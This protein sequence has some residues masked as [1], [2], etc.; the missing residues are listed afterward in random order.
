MRRR[1]WE[2]ERGKE[3]QKSLAPVASKCFF[4][5]TLSLFFHAVPRRPLRG[6]LNIS[7]N[8]L[9]ESERRADRQEG[10]ATPGEAAASCWTGFLSGARRVTPPGLQGEHILDRREGGGGGSYCQ[11]DPERPAVLWRAGRCDDVFDV[12]GCRCREAGSRQGL[13]VLLNRMHPQ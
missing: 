1:R 12:I 5:S 3:G 7:G 10:R 2:G 4:L 13:D 8:V 9:V 11:T 6:R